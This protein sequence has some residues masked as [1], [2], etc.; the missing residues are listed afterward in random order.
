MSDTH[1]APK[2]KL[3]A[4]LTW[5]GEE[6]PIWHVVH[7]DGQLYCPPVVFFDVMPKALQMLFLQWLNA[8]QLSITMPPSLPKPGRAYYLDDVQS[9]IEGAELGGD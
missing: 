5:Q 3:A 6:I 4:M 8:R 2:L 9:A 1:C 7:L